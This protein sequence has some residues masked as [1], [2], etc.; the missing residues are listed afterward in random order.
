MTKK[1]LVWRLKERPTADDIVKL[2]DAKV[3]TADEAKTIAFNS[4][5][6]NDKIAKLEKEIEL[7]KDA[8]RDSQRGVAIDREWLSHRPLPLPAQPFSFN[9]VD[10]FKV[11]RGLIDL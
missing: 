7:L 8:L 9:T 3:I 1:E 2:I 5:D 4:V 11:F 6:E 10:P